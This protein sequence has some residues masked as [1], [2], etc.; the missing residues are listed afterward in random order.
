M[1]SIELNTLIEELHILQSFLQYSRLNNLLSTTSH[2]TIKREILKI[3]EAIE[4]VKNSQT[5]V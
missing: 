1:E 4:H 3:Q 5:V 2:L